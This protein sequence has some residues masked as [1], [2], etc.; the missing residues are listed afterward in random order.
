MDK[1][2]NVFVNE[3]LYYLYACMISTIF[4]DDFIFWNFFNHC[5]KTAHFC[6][7]IFIQLIL[8]SQGNIET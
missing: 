4:H 3:Y 6:F 2:A 8:I 1:Y 5:I 7:T